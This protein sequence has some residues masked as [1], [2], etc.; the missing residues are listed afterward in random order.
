[1][2]LGGKAEGAALR[3]RLEGLL[4]HVVRPAPALAAL[5]LLMGR[6][7]FGSGFGYRPRPAARALGFRVFG[8]GHRLSNGPV[9]RGLPWPPQVPTDI[10]RRDFLQ[11][12][13]GLRAPRKYGTKRAASLTSPPGV[14]IKPG[15][16]P[17]LFT[18]LGLFPFVLW[19]QCGVTVW[20]SVPSGKGGGL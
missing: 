13:Q 7:G 2:D 12:G 20:E 6:A 9:R 11:S 3:R 10:G 1:M 16:S 4:G 5:G 17:D 18:G 14:T 15:V 19:D 8:F